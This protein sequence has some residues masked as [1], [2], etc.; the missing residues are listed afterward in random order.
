MNPPHQPR[1][2]ELYIKKQLMFFFCQARVSA[3]YLSLNSRP[4][5][6]PAQKNNNNNNNYCKKHDLQFRCRFSQKQSSIIL[7]K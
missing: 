2:G 3:G 5:L 4:F 1:S 7:I 6:R